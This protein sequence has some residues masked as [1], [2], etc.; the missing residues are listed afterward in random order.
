MFDALSERLFAA[1]TH[2]KIKVFIGELCAGVVLFV[3]ETSTHGDTE[4]KPIKS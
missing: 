4:G 1:L 2:L 3:E